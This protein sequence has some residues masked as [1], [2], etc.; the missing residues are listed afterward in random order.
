MVNAV[1]AALQQ[2]GGAPLA[3]YQPKFILDQVL[4]ACK[5]ENIA[6]RIRPDLIAMAIGNLSTEHANVQVPAGGARPVNN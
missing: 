3:S 5:F 1:I 4:A 6:P 2:M